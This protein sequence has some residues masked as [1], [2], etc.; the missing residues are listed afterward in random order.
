MSQAPGESIAAAYTLFAPTQGEVTGPLCQKRGQKVKWFWWMDKRLW[1]EPPAQSLFTLRLTSTP[2]SC[3]LI[4]HSFSIYLY[5]ILHMNI[6]C[7]C[8][9]LFHYCISPWCNSSLYRNKQSISPILWCQGWASALLQT[10]S[11][12]V[13]FTHQHHSTAF[14][15]YP[16][17]CEQIMFI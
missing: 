8:E 10:H 11:A 14:S 13:D 1:A 12:E 6:W 17:S 7:L 2:S 4:K 16:V 3:W 5:E 15:I 9:L